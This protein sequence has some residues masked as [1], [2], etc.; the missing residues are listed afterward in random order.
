MK[1]QPQAIPAG[2][3]AVTP[4][5]TLKD[6]R[7]AIAFYEKAFGAKTLDVFPG[8]DGRGIMH[9]LIQIGDSVVMLGDEN[10]QPGL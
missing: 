4:C 5:L 9:A 3:H 2:F 6:S 1:T 8:P 7:Q 10:A